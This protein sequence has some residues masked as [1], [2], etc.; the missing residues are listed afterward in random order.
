M[1]REEAI[2]LLQKH[3]KT[4]NLLKHCL[5]VEAVMRALAR[6]LGEDEEKW[7]LAGLLHDIDYEATKDDPERHSLVG[8]EMLEQEGLDPEIVYAVK[9]HNEVHGLPRE[10]RLS[11]A[12]YAT[13]PLTGLIVAAA[14]IRPE[15]KL[16]PVDVS[17]LLNRYQEKSFARGA[18]REQIAACQELGLSLEDFLHIGLEAMKGIADELGL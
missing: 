12:L 16:A 1:Q 7:G 5:A 4:P 13:D 9:A 14:L 17:F 8:G 2:K 10:D 6:H 11:K 15:K 18:K 3:I